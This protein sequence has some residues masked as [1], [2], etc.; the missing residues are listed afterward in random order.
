MVRSN[1]TNGVNMASVLL[2]V[3]L[4]GGVFVGMAAAILPTIA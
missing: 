1:N 4:V 2:N 3:I